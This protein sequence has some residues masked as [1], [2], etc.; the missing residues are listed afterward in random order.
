MV[1]LTRARGLAA[2][3]ADIEA[4]PFADGVFDCVLANRVLYHVRNLGEGLAQIARV[5]RPGGRLVAVTY[6]DHHLAELNAPLGYALRPSPFS[7]ENG[8]ALLQQAFDS[9]ERRDFSGSVR[10]ADTHALREF[11]GAYG[12]FADVDLAARAGDVPMPFTA[13]YRHCLFVARNLR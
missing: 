1:A 6:S 13:T 10:F 4:L 2:L 5:L 8:E 3:Q 11:L 12:E 9:V 7:A